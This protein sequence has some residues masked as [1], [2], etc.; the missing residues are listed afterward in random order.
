MISIMSLS[1]FE[2]LGKF[3]QRGR[4]LEAGEAL[5]RAGDPV[6]S[7]FLVSSGHVE[8]VRMLPHGTP[9]ILQRAGPGGIFAEA[10][11]F[12]DR[13]HC[14]AVARDGAL[15]QVIPRRRLEAA[16]AEDG[17][18][19]RAWAAYLA[20]G[21]Q[22]ERARAEILAL[23]TVRERL[24]AWSA[25]HDGTLPAKGAWRQL[26]LE[27]GVSPEALYREMAARR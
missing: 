5:F 27:I 20:R 13:Y 16:F 3:A 22:E 9:L 10:S 7:L 12:S 1:M 21:V 17:G 15:L 25:L 18:L 4:S 6:R 23:K 14:D 2:R 19:A 11:L 24:D 8:L 26:A